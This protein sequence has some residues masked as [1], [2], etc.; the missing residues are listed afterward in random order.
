MTPLGPTPA[1]T[2]RVRDAIVDSILQ[3]AYRAGDRLAQEK[4]AEQLGV[5]RQ[6]ISHALA[7]L[8][9]QGVL[10]ALGRKGLTVAPMDPDM[11]VQLYQIRG[12][13]DG[14]AARLSAARMARG[15]LSPRDVEPLRDLVDRYLAQDEA[16]AG[17]A[18][19]PRDL[20]RRI[21]ADMRFHVGLYRLSGNPLIEEVTRPHWVHFRRSMQAV[22]TRPGGRPQ[23]WDQHRA[24]LAAILAGDAAEAERLSIHH[25][26]TAAATAEASLSKDP[27][28]E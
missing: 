24:I 4:L 15:E 10:V 11:V 3:G 17:A 19:R 27:S 13:L 20:A 5:S 14:L 26:D 6:P 22:L 23:A 1:L 2:E 16:A 21:N 18:E 28:T 9:E 12:P 25:T 7:L 8:K